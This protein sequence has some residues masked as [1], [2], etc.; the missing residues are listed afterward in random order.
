MT[1]LEE[2]TQTFKRWFEHC[3]ELGW[4]WGRRFPWVT[5]AGRKII[6]KRERFYF[7]ESAYLL[8]SEK[9]TEVQT[10]TLFLE[11]PKCI[12]LK[13]KGALEGTRICLAFT[14]R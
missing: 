6:H 7:T 4:R 1:A 9:F 11:T 5:Q 13:M 12:M 10:E 2:A 8:L 3:E 14:H